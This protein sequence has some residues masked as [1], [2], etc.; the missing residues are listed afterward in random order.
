MKNIL[1]NQN[2]NKS[3]KKTVHTTVFEKNYFWTIVT[4]A[5]KTQTFWVFFRGGKRLKMRSKLNKKIRSDIVDQ[6]TR[7]ENKS[8]KLL[9]KES[10]KSNY[11]LLNS[12]ILKNLRIPT[13]LFLINN[14]TF[15][16]RFV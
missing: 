13:H 8:G 4:K 11:F 9:K 7:S 10:V 5:T 2:S 6:V 3:E 14:E 16:E 12:T 15:S 1:N